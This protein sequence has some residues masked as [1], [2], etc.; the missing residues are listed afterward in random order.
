MDCM[1]YFVYLLE[2]SDRTYY[3]GCSKDVEKRV[4]RHNKG[5]GAKYTMTRLPVTLL[6]SEEQ[7]TLR[8]AMRREREIKKWP[9]ERKEGL[10]D[11]LA[12]N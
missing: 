11:A 5:R 2:C 8:D 7:P 10:I 3:C 12:R 4:E 9:R 1:A 6:Y